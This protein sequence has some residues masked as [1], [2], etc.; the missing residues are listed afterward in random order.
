METAKK[1]PLT[2]LLRNRV[3]PIAT[4]RQEV[5]MERSAWKVRADDLRRVAAKTAE[6]E[7]ER[8]MLALAER[9][10]EAERASKTGADDTPANTGRRSRRKG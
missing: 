8:K 2:S 6:P 10:E 5:P 1:A 4:I 9:I 7:R 3:E